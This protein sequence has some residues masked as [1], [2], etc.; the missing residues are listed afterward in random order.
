M[1]IS[2]LGL[3]LIKEYVRHNK[4]Q[5]M[6]NS[7]HNK[8]GDKSYRFMLDKGLTQKS[9][10]ETVV[11]NLKATECYK[12]EQDNNSAYKGTVYFFK[13]NQLD[14]TLYVKVKIFADGSMLLIM[15]IHPWGMYDATEGED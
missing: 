14:E 2:D 7:K 6:F 3:T 4:Y 15:S 12:S 5:F 10:A 13:T 8:L 11:L 1:A 9:L